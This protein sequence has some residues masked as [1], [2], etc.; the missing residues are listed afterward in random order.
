MR[1]LYCRK[2][3]TGLA[4]RLLV[5][6]SK[7]NGD[8]PHTKLNC[9]DIVGIFTRDIVNPECSG[10]VYS[11]RRTKIVIACE[12]FTIEEAVCNIVL[13]TNEV[14]HK[15]QMQV[16]EQCERLQPDHHAYRLARVLMKEREPRFGAC[17][18]VTP[19]NG[20]L[21]KKQVE[22]V[23]FAVSGCQDVGVVH[24]PPGT[25]KTTTVVEVILQLVGRGQRVLATAPSNIAVDNILEQL[26]DK[27]PVVRLGHPARILPH[28]ERFSL[29][30]KVKLSD[31]S[32]LLL[33]VNKDITRVNQLILTTR[34]PERTE[35]RQHLRE[36]RKEIKERSAKA[37]LEVLGQARVVLATN[38]AAGDKLLGRY[39]S[40]YGFFDTVVI[41]EAAQALEVSC[42]IPLLKGRRLILAGDHK[43]LPPTIKSAEAQSG[44]SVT[45]MARVCEAYPAAVVMLEEQ[46]RMHDDI[47]TWPSHH[48]YEGRLI[49]NDTVK[50]WTLPNTEGPLMFLDTIGCEM[51]DSG[52]AG[53][54][55]FNLGEASLVDVFV[56]EL[57]TLG[58][59]EIGVITPYNAQVEVLHGLG[60]TCEVSTVDGFQGREKDA[61][62]ISMVRS[63]TNREIGFLA[64]ER[65][66]NVA[67]TRAKKLLCIIGDSSTLGSNR[68][69]DTF[70]SFI[71]HLQE[72]AIVRGVQVYYQ[73]DPRIVFNQG[74]TQTPAKPKLTH[75]KPVKPTRDT[76]TAQTS[77]HQTGPDLYITAEENIRKF[78][79]EDEETEMRL[80][81]MP[82]NIREKVHRL[83]EELGLE[84]VSR[85]T[86]AGRHVLIS[87]PTPTE[88]VPE[89]ETDPPVPQV[90]VPPPS[91]PSKPVAIKPK[92][93]PKVVEKLSE[94]DELKFLDDIVEASQRCGYPGCAEAL[95][96]I[97]SSCKYC[98]RTYCL[99]HAHAELH[100]CAEEVRAAA[101]AGL[102]AARPHQ[103]KEYE[104]KAL[105]DRLHKKQADMRPAPKPK[106]KK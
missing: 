79:C 85:G 57:R 98:K 10:V 86:G 99:N 95:H 59:Q 3:K 105:L 23:D 12:E 53:D 16:L 97:S 44:L 54:S 84:H 73:H 88:D 77:M 28:L 20:R 100:G 15:R 13:L 93:P 4:G 40:S 36:L 83:C 78:V 39:V 91:K 27:V 26:G 31:Q 70:R 1:G 62:I 22:A 67:I 94:E 24:G 80:D 60:L 29:D 75:T 103:L 35:H 47:M 87:K 92:K 50:N 30:H 61:I 43:Q 58:V 17:E 34:G 96:A 69:T 21:N 68:S 48:F 18:G 76:G 81:P 19:V 55:K 9:G 2:V 41:D 42:W 5:S 51:R 14:T 102:T 63:N 101:R 64:D 106:K 104:R 32:Q 71:S 56:Q 90:D 66:L 7:E 33:S 52:D 6:L 89:P 11:L 74:G 38:I 82:G 72:H 45:L 8:L 49:S 46:Y 25:G 37:V 65:R